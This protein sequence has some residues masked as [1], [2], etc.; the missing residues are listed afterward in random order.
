MVRLKKI[1]IKAFRGVRE[2]ELELEGR[3]LV[4]S[5]ENASGKSCLADALEYLFTGSIKHLEGTMGISVGRHA[6]NFAMDRDQMGI[7]AVFDPGA[8]NVRRRYD[9]KPQISDS[10]SGYWS[11]AR[12]GA[13]ILRRAGLLEFVYADPADRFR[14]IAQMVGAE[15]LDH[16]ELAMTRAH[17]RLDGQRQHWNQTAV[18]IR[19][20]IA[21]TVGT[22][23][24]LGKINEEARP[25]GL[26]AI[27]SLQD[28][29]AR[30]EEWLAAA[31]SVDQRR[32]QQLQDLRNALDASTVPSNVGLE[33]SEFLDLHTQLYLKRDVGNLALRIQEIDFLE[34]AT[35]L[36][37]QAG[38]ET[39]R[40]PLCEQVIDYGPTIERV[41]TRQAL[42]Y[43]LSEEVSELRRRQASLSSILQSLENALPVLQE[44]ILVLASP[45]ADAHDRIDA[46]KHALATAGSAF[47]EADRFRA[48]LRVD[49]LRER[50]QQVADVQAELARTI[51][52]EIDE[53]KLTDRDRAI[54]GLVDKVNRAAEAKKRLDASEVKAG[55]IERRRSL[56]ERVRGLFAAIKK[57]KIEDVYQAIQSDVVR[58]YDSLHPDEP[59]TDLKVLLSA[60]RRASTDIR[61]QAF[62]Q[63]DED[64]RAYLSEGH[65]D[66]L[67][68]CIFLA[69]MKTFRRDFRMVVLDDV[70]MSIDAGHRSRLATLLLDDFE[71][72]QVMITTHD[73]VWLDELH[74]HQRAYHAESRFL[75]LR[76]VR[77]SLVEGPVCEI[78]KPRWESIEDRLARADKIGAA[79]ATRQA[80]EWVLKEVCFITLAPAILKRSRKY[81]VADVIEPAEKRLKKLLPDR[82]ND[83]DLLFRAI[84]GAATPGNLLSH[85][86]PEAG[87]MSVNELRRFYQA[88]K[89]LADWFACSGCSRMPSYVREVSQITCIHPRCSDK[90]AWQTS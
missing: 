21:Q 43:E 50:I 82:S 59:H 68:L 30:G 90:K 49:G 44:K 29:A 1:D 42:L 19:T 61:I 34:R 67:G 57:R 6:H 83:I 41:R 55:E 10:L 40:C 12:I 65:L 15:E 18:A 84:E 7:D 60:T 56:A 80:L 58:F 48:P 76:I 64:P 27:G 3:S 4:L 63:S 37:D 8:I 88:V 79:N 23:D 75:N 69:F 78:A 39:T 54:L 72:W 46:A 17:D 14:A 26:P 77:W 47:Y 33:I 35:S 16:I 20:E 71:D 38:P 9:E 74:S 81:V 13:F 73:E 66:S 52:S 45:P 62:G 51:D 5:G 2:W 11:E 53:L 89:A 70:V 25:L 36:L 86:N 31:K 85:D 22:A 28:A 32:V 24:I 87:N